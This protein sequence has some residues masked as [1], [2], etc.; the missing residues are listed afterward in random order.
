VLQQKIR[1]LKLAI[2]ARPCQCDVH[3]VLGVRGDPMK[4]PEP[5]RMVGRVM[6]TEAP[7]PRT[8]CLIKPTP[9]SREVPYASSV[10]EIVGQRPNQSQ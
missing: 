1:N 5:G 10:R 4:V 9:D 6:L 8:A 3:D 2:H 7:K